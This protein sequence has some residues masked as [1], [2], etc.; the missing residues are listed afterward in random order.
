MKELKEIDAFTSKLAGRLFSPFCIAHSV[1][2]FFTKLL[3][4]NA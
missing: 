3:A 4:L 2:K 1:H